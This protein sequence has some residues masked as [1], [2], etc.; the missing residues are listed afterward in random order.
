MLVLSLLDKHHKYLLMLS[1]SHLGHSSLNSFLS[2]FSLISERI[3]RYRPVII[4]LKAGR[5]LSD[6]GSMNLLMKNNL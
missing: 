4:D 1:V 2:S 3:S 5:S 6:E